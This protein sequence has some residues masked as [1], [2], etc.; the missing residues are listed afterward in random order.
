MST[1]LE[2]RGECYQI[3]EEKVSEEE[4]AYYQV[5]KIC[6]FQHLIMAE[7]GKEANQSEIQNADANVV[8]HFFSVTGRPVKWFLDAFLPQAKQH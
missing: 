4:I 3:R 1:V 2:F 7:K 6:M 8:F 5:G